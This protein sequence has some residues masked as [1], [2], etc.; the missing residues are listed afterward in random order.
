MLRVWVTVKT[1]ESEMRW[2]AVRTLPRSEERA[3]TN[4][5]HQGYEVFSPTIARRVKNARR[6]IWKT[7]P[8]FPGYA[9]VR[10]DASRP[11][12]RPLD[13]TFGVASVLKVG[14]QPAPLP[15]GVVEQLILLAEQDAEHLGMAQTIAI[16]DTVRVT[17]GP[18]E[19]WIGDVLSLKVQD[20]VL[21][22]VSM[23]T[24]SIELTVPTRLVERIDADDVPEMISGT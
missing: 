16:G 11:R 2:Y 4:L 17:G 10:L 19:S 6:E 8:L 14:S 18:F 5:R 9:F 20:R 21:L 7:A 15:V 12:W 22:L 13:S 3:R 24:R 1:A 23:A